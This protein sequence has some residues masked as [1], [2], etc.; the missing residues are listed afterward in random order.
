VP[1]A[2]T[3]TS[4][5]LSS[6]DTQESSLAFER[7]NMTMLTSSAGTDPHGWRN[8]FNYFGWGSLDADVYRDAAYSSFDAAAKVAV[9]A[10]A[11]THKPV[12]ILA[13]A[14]GHAQRVIGLRHRRRIPH[15]P[16]SIERPSRHVHHLC[17][18]QLGRHLG[19]VL[20]IP[21]DRL[22]HP[23]PDRRPDWHE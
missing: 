20:A 18:V 4:E 8:A 11:T 15:R 19:S 12:G 5:R 14:G 2:E 6:Y 13:R 9:S 23:G 22:A 3:Y 17:A 10:I 1:A 21:G 7:D 16:A